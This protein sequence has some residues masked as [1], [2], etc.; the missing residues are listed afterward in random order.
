MVLVGQ[1]GAV[2]PLAQIKIPMQQCSDGFAGGDTVLRMR[3]ITDVPTH[4]LMALMAKRRGFLCVMAKFPT[5][6]PPS[7]HLIISLCNWLNVSPPLHLKLTCGERSGTKWLPW[8]CML[9][10][11]EVSVPPFLLMS[12]MIK[13]Y[14]KVSLLVSLLLW[15]FDQIS[16]PQNVI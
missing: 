3:H 10:V 12:F 2:F 16:E 5:L 1:Q 6:R 14:V 8:C 15:R 4:S 7:G 9:V 11:V 13:H